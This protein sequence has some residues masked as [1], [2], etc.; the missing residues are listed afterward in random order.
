MRGT[1]FTVIFALVILFS[2]CTTMEGGVVIEN[3]PPPPP[4]K[5]SDGPG[6]RTHGPSGIPPGHL[7]PPGKCRIWYPGRPPGHQGPKGR[8]EDLARRMPPG[9]WLVYGGSKGGNYRVEEYDRYR[10]DLVISIRIYDVNTG[11]LISIEKR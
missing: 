1:L 9:A 8:C 2:A 7:P 4:T 3:P 11:T 5:K 6:Y 10:S